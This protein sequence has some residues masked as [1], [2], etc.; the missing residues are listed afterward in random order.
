[1]ALLT[2]V[3]AVD[4]WMPSHWKIVVV[5]ENGKEEMKAEGDVHWIAVKFRGHP[6]LIE[7]VFARRGSEKLYLVLGGKR[8]ELTDR[9][10]N[11]EVKGLLFYSIVV[12]NLDQPPPVEILGS[13]G[14]WPEDPEPHD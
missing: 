13:G 10:N 14:G 2:I 12:T 1:M 6:A 7:E 3:I 9:V 11:G 4:L 5:K 8:I